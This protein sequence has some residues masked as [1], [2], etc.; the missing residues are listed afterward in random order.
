MENQM[1][2]L[3]ANVNSKRAERLVTLEEWIQQIRTNKTFAGGTMKPTASSARCRLWYR[4][5]TAR[6]EGR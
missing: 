4:Q 2:T 6:T 3:F 5:A 1:M